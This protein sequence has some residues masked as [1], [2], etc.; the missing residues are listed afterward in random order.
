MTAYAHLPY[1]PGVGV[2]L[3]NAEGLIFAGQRTDRDQDAW[4]MPQGGIDA[5]EDPRE[6]ALRELW[7]ET[8]VDPAL[9]RIEAETSGWVAYDLPDEIVPNIWKGRFRGQRQKWYLMRF[10]G[11]DDQVNIATKHPEFARWKWA[12]PAELRAA[13]VPFKRPLYE[14][15]FAE[16]EQHI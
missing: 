7:E 1:R 16:L 13:I 15:V 9:V 12:T 3:A 10:L 8:G 14:A 2:I 5:G 11:R 6:A 4:Q